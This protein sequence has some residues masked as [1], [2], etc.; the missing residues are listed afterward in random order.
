MPN[1]NQLWFNLPVKD[2]AKSQAF[3]QAIGFILNEQFNNNE[4]SAS[5]YVSTNNTVMMLFQEESFSS[6]IRSRKVTYENEILFS[7]SANSVVEVDQLA[8]RVKA[9]GGQLFS[10]P[11]EI[12]GWMYGCGFS[13]PDGHKWNVLFMDSEKIPQK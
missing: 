8:L 10:A 13:D 11:K 7:I 4:Q 2:V 6:M 9:S 5:F 12:Q 1:P 3:Y